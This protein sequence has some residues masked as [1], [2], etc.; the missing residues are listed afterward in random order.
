[1]SSS[2]AVPPTP[3]PA[4]VLAPGLSAS[5]FAKTTHGLVRGSD[6]YLVTAVVDPAEAGGDAGRLVDGRPRGVPIVASVAA[7]L[8]V[9]RAAGSRPTACIIGIAVPGGTVPA[10]L[11]DALAEA[12]AA[13]LTLVNGLHQRLADDAE[14]ARLAAEHGGGIIDLR[15]PR[16]LSE[17][18]F[19]SGEILDLAVPRVAVLG[20]DCAVGKRTTT[21]MLR[22][23]LRRRGLGAEM[24]YTGQTGW[25]LGVRHGFIFDATPNDFVSGELEGAILACAAE[26]DPQV[27]LLEGQSA[28]RNPS[29]PCGAELLLSAAAAGVVL[30]HA[31]GRRW[32]K[33][34]EGRV[35]IADVESEVELIDRYGVPVWAITLSQ[36]G[37][38][39][40]EAERE[41]DRL[42]SRLDIPV[43]LPFV[44]GVEAV[45]DALTSQL[46]L[47]AAPGRATESVG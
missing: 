40:A 33:G 14:L 46:D 19:W 37:L 7:A 6:R 23:S 11:R 36:E 43:V 27:I 2:A 42:R 39:P 12:A 1:M 10:T 47:R 21:W 15:R 24:I 26:L 25:M 44:D 20:T 4:I 45:A 30:Q 29:G 22:E 13:G 5:N 41:R 31:P 32:H 3:Q 18:R 38:A 34:M 28:L 16:P 17:L 35:P 9:S 8:E